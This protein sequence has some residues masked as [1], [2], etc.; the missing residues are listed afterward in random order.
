MIM[1]G[2]F[3]KLCNCLHVLAL[4]SFRR[5]YDFKDQS[6]VLFTLLSKVP[7]NLIATFYIH[8]PN[9]ELTCLNRMLFLL[10]TYESF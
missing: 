8:G 2:F 1:F 10:E 4:L 5:F 7:T 9:L 6:I 3:L